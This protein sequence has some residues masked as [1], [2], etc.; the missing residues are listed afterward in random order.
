[1]NTALIVPSRH[2]V[3]VDAGA[4]QL[5]S[6]VLERA[7]KDEVLD[8]VKGATRAAPVVQL[9]HGE[10]EALQVVI[11]MFG[12]FSSK[13]EIR[14]LLTSMHTKLYGEDPI[15]VVKEAK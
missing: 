8:A 4:M 11:T 7:I 5:A 14:D 2:Y 1:M 15:I 9:T 13:V 6:N 12:M 10:M 3:V